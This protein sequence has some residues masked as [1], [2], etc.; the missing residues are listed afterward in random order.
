MIYNIA[1]DG[2]AGSGKSTIAKLLAEELNFNYLNSGSLY[3]CIALF[4]I[5]NKLTNQIPSIFNKEF[6]NM[7]NI[8]WSIDVILLNG[9]D[10]TN[11]IRS[12]ECSSLASVIAIYQDVRN[13]VNKNIQKISNEKNIIVDG[14]DIGTL[15]LP[16]ANLKIFLDASI[17]VR[18]NR[19]FKH[20]QDLG[21]HSKTIN[22]ISKDIKERDDRDY[23]REIAPLAKADDAIIIDCSNLTI[24]EVIETVKAHI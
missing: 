18:A 22:E 17:E 21:I 16:N 11:T 9:K 24:K 12:P 5:E 8:D 20:N 19:V 4:I 23:N 1:I 14:R 13:F 3:R 7:I 15:V 2:P 10:V 6:F